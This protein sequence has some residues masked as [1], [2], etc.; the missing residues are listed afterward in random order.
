MVKVNELKTDW[1]MILLDK[2]LCWQT[3]FL[4][5]F[6]FCLF[7]GE[8]F[9]ADLKSNVAAIKGF[10]LFSSGEMLTLPQSFG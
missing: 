5:S 6:E 2:W 9:D 10:E 3:L 8:F 4:N 7:S 1:I